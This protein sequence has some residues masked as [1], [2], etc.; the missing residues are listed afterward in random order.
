[1]KNHKILFLLP[2]SEWKNN[3]A[4]AEKESLSFSFKK[5]FEIIKNTT[6]KDL[7]CT[8]K[9]YEEAK[10]FNQNIEN[11]TE[12][13][14]AISRYSGVMYSAIDF[15]N[16]S[17]RWQNFFEKYFLIFSGLY[18]ILRPKDMIANYKLP[19]ETKGLYDFW[20]TKIVEKIQEINPEYIV[21]LLPI[22]YAKLIGIGTKK[23][24]ENPLG[25]T[26]IINI[27]FLKPDGKK[28]SHGVKKIKW[29]WIKNI[30]EQNI[31]DYRDFWGEIVENE[32]VIEV[33]I[34]KK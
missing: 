15:E 24:G 14:P 33:N 29:A 23:L 31:T 5:P 10:K 25:N 4:S 32:N 3:N 28:I 19:I 12:F 21:N 27:N 20:G 16:M 34:Y 11:T 13:L 6:E 1:M 2:P 8:G 26:K 9:R 17:E 22:S 30:C 7:K 18:G